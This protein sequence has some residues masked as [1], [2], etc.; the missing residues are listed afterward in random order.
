MSILAGINQLSHIYT[1]FLYKYTIEMTHQTQP[2]FLDPVKSA[3]LSCYAAWAIEKIRNV[4]HNNSIRTTEYN[5][6][7][8]ALFSNCESSARRDKI[9]GRIPT[10]CLRYGGMYIAP[11][12]PLCKPISHV[13]KVGG[14]ASHWPNDVMLFIQSTHLS[15]SLLMSASQQ[16]IACAYW[17]IVRAKDLILWQWWTTAHLCTMW[18]DLECRSKKLT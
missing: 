9:A 13:M 5:A 1:H 12:P 11:A 17:W 18:W 7:S 16:R 15:F 10:V 2:S 6:S 3:I 8:Q 4:S 14:P